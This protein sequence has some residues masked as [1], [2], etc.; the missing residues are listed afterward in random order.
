[1]LQ[2]AV[3][4]HQPINLA[5]KR[6]DQILD[7]TL[8]PNQEERD[9][10]GDAGLVA[11]RTVQVAPFVSQDLDLPAARAGIRAG[12]IIAAINGK[13]LDSIEGLIAFLAQN[14][15]TPVKVTVLRD[16]QPINLTVT[17]VATTDKEHP[18]RLGFTS[19][20][21][22][23]IMRLPFS[24]AFVQSLET[25]KRY[26][27]LILELVE[28]LVQRKAS[29]KQLVGPIGI[30]A[31]AGQAAREGLTPLLGLAALLSLNLGLFNLLPIPILDGGLVLLL[32]IESIMRKDI[33]QPVK[34]RI[35]Q[36]AFAFL[37][38]LVVISVYN[39]VLRQVPGLASRMQ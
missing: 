11:K 4:P 35:Y 23:H 10:P 26:S 13:P 37:I 21:P 7:M 16:G 39:D 27:K 19:T 14:E 34:E 33:S 25:N 22:N 5:V 28:R 17:P 38:F 9:G 15:T 29:V 12:D 24:K 8:T 6:G 20:D 1:M 36:V 32:F 31:A 30:G 3:N 2:V 18:Y